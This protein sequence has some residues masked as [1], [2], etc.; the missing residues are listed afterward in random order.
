MSDSERTISRVRARHT[1][2]TL[3]FATLFCA[4]LLVARWGWTGTVRFSSFFG[5]LLLAWIPMVLA[6]LIRRLGPPATSRRALF[7]TAVVCWVLFFPNAPYIVTDI[8][9]MK[10]FG[11]DGVPRWFDMMMT[12]AFACSGLFLGCLSLYSMHLLVRARFGWR[13]AWGFA[14]GMLALGS[15]GIYLGRFLR[16]NS[17]DV[18]AHPQK[19]ISEIASIAEPT[20]L[21]EAAA[22]SA[23][24]FGFSLVA[25]SFVVSMSRLHETRVD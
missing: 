19:L 13:R 9:H 8:I 2:T 4:A 17:W 25:Y 7:W 24:F 10:K 22:F 12:M 11:M 16:L 15:F 18:V 6:L 23:T 21:G 1:L 3:L 5:N 14:V 20:R